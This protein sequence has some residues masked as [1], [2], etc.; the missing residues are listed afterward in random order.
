[1]S[2]GAYAQ[3]ESLDDMVDG[4]IEKS[5]PL[6]YSNNPHMSDDVLFLDARKSEEYMRRLS[7]RSPRNSMC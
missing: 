2:F 6:A 3:K 1:M 4:L 7:E 5:I